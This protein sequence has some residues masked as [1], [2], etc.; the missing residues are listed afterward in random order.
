MHRQEHTNILQYIPEAWFIAKGSGQC[1][2]GIEGGSEHEAMLDAGIG[3]CNILKTSYSI[4]VHS[5]E[6]RQ[7]LLLEGSIIPA[8]SIFASGVQG[9]THTAA[10]AFGRVL[11]AGSLKPD[12][13][14]LC[15]N[16][17][18]EQE[19]F[20][21]LSIL[22]QLHHSFNSRYLDEEYSLVNVRLILQEVRISMKYGTA[23]V[24]VCF[25]QG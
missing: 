7:P 2:F 18:P 10:I 20:A 19:R 17:Y 21:R 4:P 12:A 1:D 25:C 6:I 9:E 16:I 3:H 5:R 8:V 24:S 15:K 14:I 23:M 13:F 11:N 22:E